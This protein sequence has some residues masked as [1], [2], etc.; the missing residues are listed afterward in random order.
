M[1]SEV[2]EL[3]TPLKLPCGAI[4]SNRLCKA[5]MTEGLADPM[6]RATEKHVTLYRRWAQSGAG[7]L[8]TG[9]VQVDRRSLERSG[10]VRIEG[11]QD[12]EQ[13]TRL[14]SFAKAGT[15]T[16]NHIWAQIGHAG[17]QA[18][19]SVC[20]TPVAPSA[21][22][23]ELMAW[24]QEPPRAL[25][26]DEILDIIW[27]FANAAAV[28][29]EAGFTGVQIH[30]AHGYL[31]SQFLSPKSNIRTDAWGGSLENRARF[32]LEVIRATRRTVGSDFPIGVKMNS[33]DFQKKGF[34]H[35]DSMAVVELLN[36]ENIDLLELSGGTF[37]RAAMIGVGDDEQLAREPV[38]AST[39]AR[40][41]YF[42]V[43]TA[44][45]RKI[46]KMPVMATGGF[47]RRS[48]MEG[49]LNDGT[50]DV[51]G[52]GRPFCLDPIIAAKLMSGD[53]K[54]TPAFESAKRL[55]AEER[56][57]KT[58]DEIHAAEVFGQQSL[59][60]L[61]L[62][63]M[64]EGGDPNYSRSL[65]ATAIEFAEKEARIDQAILPRL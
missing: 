35:A 36:S 10:N 65:A 1:T 59:L 16:G 50:C 51:V 39:A 46:A 19:A 7:L 27:R 3:S 49:A 2:V 24:R 26:E 60:Y 6:G 9:N 31:I 30:A 33:A 45:A 53:I 14:R 20:P 17:R 64:G 58:A 15:S 41:A 4:L 61:G 28:C 38:R 56:E 48:S 62:F 21:V 43:Y 57:G 52:L 18:A 22:A 8:L 42:A 13:M 5:A 23:V 32:L 37:E 11:K 55:T 12:A 40:E 29:R 54:E 63:D 47:R 44:D 25:R 34:T